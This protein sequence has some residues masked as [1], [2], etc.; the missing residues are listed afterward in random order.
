MKRL[1]FNVAFVCLVMLFSSGIF[2]IN[3]TTTDAQAGTLVIYNDDPFGNDIVV[4]DRYSNNNIVY[5]GYLGPHQKRSVSVVIRDGYASVSV[6][7]KQ[8]GRTIGY[9][10]MKNGDEVKGW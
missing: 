10:W 1:S 4:R 9:S 6:L 2:L 7:N 8:S 3:G 5:S